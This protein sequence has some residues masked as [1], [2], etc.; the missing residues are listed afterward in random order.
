MGLFGSHLALIL[1]LVVPIACI[2]AAV[3]DSP[4]SWVVLDIE[5]DSEDSL[6]DDPHAAT[7]VYAAAPGRNRLPAG[8][9]ELSPNGR[10]SAGIQARSPPA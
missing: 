3:A 4:V 1:M 2:A 6:D 10:A 9:P 8:L 7:Q 5:A